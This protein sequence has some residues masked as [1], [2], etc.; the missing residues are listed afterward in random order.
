MILDILRDAF[1][2]LASEATALADFMIS[3]VSQNHEELLKFIEYLHYN[4]AGS[5][6]VERLKYYV[7]ENG[8]IVMREDTDVTVTIFSS[9]EDYEVRLIKEYNL[10]HS[11]ITTT[12]ELARYAIPKNFVAPLVEEVASELPR[13]TLGYG[14][15]RVERVISSFLFLMTLLES[16]NEVARALRSFFSKTVETYLAV[17]R[18]YHELIGVVRTEEADERVRVVLKNLMEGMK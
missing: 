18:R 14:S 2:D 16:R 4:G 15:P 8:R 17:R 5:F 3:V 9:V 10:S 12:K 7:T 11:M 13:H 6:K 1:R